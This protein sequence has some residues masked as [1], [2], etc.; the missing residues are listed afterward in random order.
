MVPKVQRVVGFG[1]LS[2][3]TLTSQGFSRGV[4]WNVELTPN[5]L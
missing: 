3:G 4:T 5:F 1:S 2:Y